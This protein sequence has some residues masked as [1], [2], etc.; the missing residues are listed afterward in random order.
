MKLHVYNLGPLACMVMIAF[1]PPAVAGD[2]MSVPTVELAQSDRPPQGGRPPREAIEA[3]NS[4]GENES[5]NVALQDGTVLE[6][7][8]QKPPQGRDNAMA[9]VPAGQPPRS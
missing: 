6:G 7:T 1:V 8:C 5:C 9:C 2:A 3:C 4:K